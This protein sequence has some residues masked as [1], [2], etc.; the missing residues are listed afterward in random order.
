MDNNLNDQTTENSEGEEKSTSSYTDPNAGYTEAEPQAKN[1]NSVP[2]EAADDNLK[3]EEK[4][5]PAYI[6]GEMPKSENGSG[7]GQSAP[8]GSAGHSGASDGTYENNTYNGNSYYN[9]TDQSGAYT[10]GYS[11]N[12]YQNSGYNTGFNASGY[13]NNYNS[14]NNYQM[15]PKQMDLSPLS[16]GEWLLTL[17]VGIIPCAGL[18][19]Y[20]IW[21]FGNSGNLNRRNY[22]R[23][24]LILQVISYVLVAF[25]ILIVVVGGGI[26][27]YGY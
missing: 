3:Q 22:C 24:S 11:D 21:A 13:N 9:G 26:S 12:Q 5:H 15:P 20:I 6:Y 25:F 7:Y 23:A 19:L 18:I 16:T 1:D 8:G 17:I 10:N 2:K 4:S 14:Q 27:Y